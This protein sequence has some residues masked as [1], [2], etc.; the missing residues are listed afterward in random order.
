MTSIPEGL[1]NGTAITTVVIPVGV[2]TINSN[3]FWNCRSLTSVTLPATINLIDSS[4][5]GSTAVSDVYFAGE[6]DDVQCINIAT[7]N[8]LLMSA[9]WHCAD[10][11]AAYPVAKSGTMTSGLRW[12]LDQDGVLTI[13]GRGVIPDYDSEY[14][15]PWYESRGEITRIMVSEGVRAIGSCAFYNCNQAAS[16]SLPDSVLIIGSS[17]FSNCKA[18]TGLTLPQ[19][20]K[21]LD[22][23][24]FSNCSSLES[25]SIPSS[26]TSME[27]SVFSNCSALT[28]VTLSNGLSTVSSSAFSSCNL[29]TAVIPEGITSLDYSSFA[30][31]K[32]MTS[33]TL[34]SSIQ[35]VYSNTFNNTAITD[36]YYA[37]TI[38]EIQSITVSSGNTPLTDAVWHCADGDASYTAPSGGSVNTSISWSVDSSN[39]LTISGSG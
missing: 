19:G 29:T 25:V 8:S 24:A 22:S 2:T 39:T 23:Y 4:A 5:F 12:V 33:V 20:L 38:A 6:L 15:A 32:S 30:N 1:M 7:T 11:T 34:P 18:L 36:V 21:Q 35:A 16:V 31:N 28:G 10:Q 14:G 17:A 27:D 37:G 9:M 26:V 13:T 3:A